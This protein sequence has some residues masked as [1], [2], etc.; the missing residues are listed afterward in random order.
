MPPLVD[1]LLAEI[2]LNGKDT[3]GLT[4]ALKG[5]GGLPATAAS[6]PAAGE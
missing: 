4:A 3:N 6:D 1:Q 2:G 5:N